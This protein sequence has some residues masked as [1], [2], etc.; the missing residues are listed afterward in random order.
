MSLDTKP[1]ARFVYYTFIRKTGGSVEERADAL[2]A[3]DCEVTKAP[4]EFTDHRFGSRFSTP[5]IP[6]SWPA[7]RIPS[8]LVSQR[9]KRTGEIQIPREAQAG[10]YDLVVIGSPT[11]WLTT[12]MPVRSYLEST[13]AKRV[14]ADKIGR[15]HVELQSL[16]HLV[17]RLLL[18]KKKK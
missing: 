15:A 9:L 3:R 13:E 10:D 5:N 1:R 7:L 12:N 17:C 2:T 14:M 11:W 18:E 8:I 4:L 6:M 16:R